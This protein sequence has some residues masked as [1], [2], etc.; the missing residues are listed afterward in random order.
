MSLRDELISLRRNGREECYRS[1][2]QELRLRIQRNPQQSKYCIRTG[3]SVEMDT[4][5]ISR[6]TKEKIS[7]SLWDG[8]LT[9]EIPEY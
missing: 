3:F 9:V 7:A 4:E 5:I 8:N 6:L 2:L 1:F